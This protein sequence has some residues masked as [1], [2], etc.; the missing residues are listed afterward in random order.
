MRT[1]PGVIQGTQMWRLAEHLL[2]E[3]LQP[4]VAARRDRGESWQRIAAELHEA[5]GGVLDINR[6]TLR[7]WFRPDQEEVAPCPPM[8]APV[9]E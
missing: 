6:E 2:G 3:P 9:L 7:I 5:S 4:W 8:G 1:M